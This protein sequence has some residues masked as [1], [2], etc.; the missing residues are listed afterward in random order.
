MLDSLPTDLTSGGVTLSSDESTFGYLTET[1]FEPGADQAAAL[2]RQMDRD[3]YL[4][5]KGLIPRDLVLAAR[6]EI[7]L[8]FA[9]VGEI[10]AV[11]HPVLDGVLSGESWADQVNLLAFA[12]SLRRGRAYS[13]VVESKEIY[14][15]WETFLGGK[16]RSFDFRWP[17]F[18]RLGEATGIHC[19]GPYISRGTSS[20][21][22]TWVPLG[23]IELQNGPIMV[24]EGSHR[25][26][27]LTAY[28]QQDADRDKI[29]WLSSDALAL[30][31][32]L[33]GRWLSANFE[34]GDALV[35]GRG[36]VHAS[37]D[38]AS[39]ERR[40][41]LSSDTRYQL[42]SEPL[43][44]RYNGKGASNPHGGPRRAFYPGRAPGNNE[45]FQEEWKL[46]DERGRLVQH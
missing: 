14:T 32:R 46:V 15:F 28:L 41:R 4:Y 22:S 20:V 2:R 43:D 21:W 17:R 42:A 34:A 38:N 29:G 12:E 19:D 39:S 3:G 13:D 26:P 10:D 35:F 8:K 25:N 16:V 33:G 40:C 44:E 11:N 7:L 31:E 27:E 24:L 36:L 18:M 23:D 1:R 30:R 6:E 5:L 37:I 45:E 9:I